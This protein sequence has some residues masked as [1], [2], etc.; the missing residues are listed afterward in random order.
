MTSD[1]GKRRLEL[2]VVGRVQG[3]GFR[4][5]VLD[6]ARALGVSG[7][8]ANDA[9][10]SVRIVAEGSEDRLLRLLAA[11]REGPPGARI[12]RADEAWRPSTSEFDGF[13][14]MSGW[15]AGD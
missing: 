11:V 4:M 3:V 13:T 7:W 1:P 9:A 15:H 10:G 2:R 12:D 5:F 6:R 14:I 8:V